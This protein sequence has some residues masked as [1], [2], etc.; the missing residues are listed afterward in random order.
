MKLTR[1]FGCGVTQTIN[2]N[3]SRASH[4]YA[5]P[6]THMRTRHRQSRM[7]DRCPARGTAAWSP[8]RLGLVYSHCCWTS[9]SSFRDRVDLAEQL[10]R[11]R[12][13]LNTQ[14]INLSEKGA[15]AEARET[16]NEIFV[17]LYFEPSQPQGITNLCYLVYALN[18]VNHKRLH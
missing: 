7:T 11:D 17:S 8:V 13:E 4:I 9:S 18:P 14:R 3:K 6:I 10:W 15:V 16:I 1:T 5:Q 12:Q 2:I